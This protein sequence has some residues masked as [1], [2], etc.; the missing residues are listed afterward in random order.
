MGQNDVEALDIEVQAQVIFIYG[1]DSDRYWK[2]S[3]SDFIYF[4]INYFQYYNNSL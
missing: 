1:R 4:I 3:K 2:H